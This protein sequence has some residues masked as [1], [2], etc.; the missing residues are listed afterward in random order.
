MPASALPDADITYNYVLRNADGSVEQ[1]WGNDRVI[2]PAKFSQDEILIIDAWNFA[3]FFEN[4]FYTE[5]FKS[6][7]LKANHTSVD[8]V[9]PATI[10]HVFKVKAPLLA[11]GQ[12][13]CLLGGGKA[14]KNW[15]TAAPILL[16]RKAGEDYF[17]AQLDLTGESFPIAYKY[18]VYDVVNHQ[19]VRFEEGSNRVL[20]DTVAPGKQNHPERRFPPYCR[21]TTWKGAGVAIPVFSLRT[22]NSFGVGEFSDLKPLADWSVQDGTQTDPDSA[23]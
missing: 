5:P 16:S 1:D 6:V 9:V 12:T 19:F 3:G 15:D 18:G 22:E 23:D 10:T 2:S 7:L 13:L 14:L 11:Q 8:A 17:T 20:Q 21:I 4:A